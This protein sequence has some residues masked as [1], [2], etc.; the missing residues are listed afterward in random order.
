MEKLKAFF[1]KYRRPMVQL[2]LVFFLALFGFGAYQAVTYTWPMHRGQFLTASESRL[3]DRPVALYDAGLAAYQRGSYSLARSYLTEAS[4]ACIDPNGTVSESR[5]QIC[6]QIQFLLANSYFALQKPETAI[7][8]YEESLRLDPNN[9]HA[10][11]NLE[12]LKAQQA[13]ASGGGDEGTPGG[14]KRGGGKGI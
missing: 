12:L 3:A 5:E 8:A 1:Q 9:L 4:S 10:K 6:A 13:G 14:G 2:A 11:Y 7:Q